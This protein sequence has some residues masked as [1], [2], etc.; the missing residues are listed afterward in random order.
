MGAFWHQHSGCKFSYT[1]KSRIEFWLPKFQQNIAP[2]R[3][4]TRALRKAGV[5][6]RANLGMSAREKKASAGAP[7]IESCISLTLIDFTEVAT[8]HRRRGEARSRATK[9]PALH[10]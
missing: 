2:D 3:V 9:Q 8:H 6:D 7:A 4:V 5:A 10:S 1:P